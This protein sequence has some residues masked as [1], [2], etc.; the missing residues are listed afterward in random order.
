MTGCMV[1]ME[2]LRLVLTSTHACEPELEE[3]T[4]T[5]RGRGGA[6]AINSLDVGAC[7][8]SLRQTALLL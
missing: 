5:G 4:G 6:L 1:V 3:A 8:G 7:L 2:T